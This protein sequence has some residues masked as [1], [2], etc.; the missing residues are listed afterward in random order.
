ML[1]IKSSETR[2]GHNLAA[3]E[4]L[5][6]N[7]REPALFLWR[8]ARAVVMGRNQNPWC[9]TNPAA[10]K[11]N[12]VTLARRIS[13]GGT[14]YHDRGNL[15][16]A[17]LLAR[18]NYKPQNAYQVVIR[19][20]E[21][22]GLKVSREL[23]NSLSI[24]KNK[25]SGTAFC[26]RKKRVMHHGTLLIQS[27]L[28]Q[29]KKWLKPAR[30]EIK[31]K[32]VASLP[33]PVTNLRNHL[34]GLEISDLE[35]LLAD[36]FEREYA[37]PDESKDTLTFHPDCKLVRTATLRENLK[38]MTKRHSDPDWVMGKT[39]PFRVEWGDLSLT[40]VNGV[41]AQAEGYHAVTVEEL[42]GTPFDSQTLSSRLRG[43][44]HPKSRQLSRQLEASLLRSF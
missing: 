44:K 42:I 5:L 22:L 4:F 26:Y 15:N 36:S 13:G 40:I 9:E 10:L 28:E 20:L 7:L 32:A 30:L 31:T 27:D 24:G 17:I 38:R 19:A 23:K 37:R 39:P 25:F 16:Y 41:I 29:L 35:D 34:S 2:I 12:G 21:N 8:S 6:Q 43:S 14:V 18:K 3:E 1:I 11:K 33:A